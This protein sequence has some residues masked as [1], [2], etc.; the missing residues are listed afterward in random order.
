MESGDSGGPIINAK[1]QVIGL[2]FSRSTIQ[3][4]FPMV[5]QARSFLQSLKGT[6]YPG[7]Q[8]ENAEIKVLFT[9]R[10]DTGANFMQNY[11]KTEGNVEREVN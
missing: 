10:N 9:L 7:F 1:G 11:C 8:L 2:V 5:S 6:I 4:R 3:V